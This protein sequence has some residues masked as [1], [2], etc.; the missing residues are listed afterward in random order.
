MASANEILGRL[1]DFNVYAT[2]RTIVK[3]NERAFA[4]STRF[5]LLA[6]LDRNDAYLPKYTSDPFFK[7]I[8]AA[9]N[10]ARWKAYISPNKEKPA[11]VMDFYISGD[12]HRTINASLNGNIIDIYSNA[13]INS[14]INDKT[15]DKALGV[16]PNQA[17]ELM[18]KILFD[19]L[20]EE[21]N[22]KTGLY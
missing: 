6:G 2:M 7:S 15:N 10:Y 17:D 21:T 4:D 16:S 13:R 5:R 18:D 9:N 20:L 1:Q 3:R 11:D 14:D 8:E 12:Y 22:Q 19:E